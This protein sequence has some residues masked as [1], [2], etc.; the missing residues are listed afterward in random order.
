MSGSHTLIFRLQETAAHPVMTRLISARWS[1]VKLNGQEAGVHSCLGAVLV[2]G[3]METL[4]RF[5]FL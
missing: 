2:L 5:I 3:P 4:E 1:E